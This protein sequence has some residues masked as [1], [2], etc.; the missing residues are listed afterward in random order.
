MDPRYLSVVHRSVGP[1]LV[2]SMAVAS[3]A[4]AQD[5]PGKALFEDRCGTC[6]GADGNGGEHARGMTRA[7]PDLNDSQLTTLIRE[8]LP[9][10]G[11]PAINVSDA[12]LPQVIAFVRTLKPRGGFQ[13]YRKS[14]AMI[15]GRTLDGMVLNEGSEDAQV[16]S[17]DNRIHLLRSAGSGKFREVT[18][19]INW[20]SYNG[21]VGGN[22]YTTLRQIDK[23]NVRRVVPKWIFRIAGASRLQGT[24][25]VADG[26]MYVTNANECFA[27]DAG[28]GRQ[29]WR[30]QRPRSTGLAG[31]AASGINRG[32]A[33]GGDKVFMVTD[34]AHLIALSRATGL[35]LW[36][37]EMAD[38]R[39]NHGATSAPLAVG[40]LVISGT[41][42]G[43]NGAQGFVAAF[44][45]ATGKEVWRFST[46]PKLGEPAWETWKGKH[47][48]YGGANA[49]FTGTYDPD[50]NTLF[51][52]TGNPGPDYNGDE[53]GG[54]NL[55]SNCILA[56]DPATGKLKWHYQFTPHDLWDWDATET[57]M[58]INTNW[59]GRPRKLL[60][61]ANRNGF[62]YVFDRTDGKLLLAKQFIK[63]LT[64]ASG[65][66]PDGK[67]IR[68]PNQ[69]PTA[70]GTHVCPS[71]DGATNWFSPSYNPTTGFYYVQVFEKCSIYTKRPVEWEQGKAFGGGS[72]RVDTDPKPQRLLYALDLQ[73]GTRKWELP[74][75]GTGSSWGGT[76]ATSTGL[77]FFG[78]D[79][80]TF[81]AADAVSGKTLWSFPAN[82]NWHA[83]PMAYQFDGQEYIATAAVG[84]IL[85]FG[86]V[87]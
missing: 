35:L 63:N 65:I 67:P 2:A 28:N 15:S 40:S 38:W 75:T 80:G 13:P 1:L 76:L 55:Y 66:G 20:T 53:R 46:L 21:D 74:Q 12:E 44:D 62:F 82:A 11:M 47:I 58:V 70:A 52:P 19:E 81:A 5:P 24:P 26:V 57:P 4:W 48:E 30:Y 42:G 32:V 7:A 77:V 71:Q 61:Q 3:I 18:S 68:N 78:D 73:T 72:Q 50:T 83:S 23:S 43:D 56:L 49:W 33:L 51:W 25:V 10:R 87:E 86:L 8:G 79:S 34:N 29:I 45:Q 39:R 64:W 69:E 27:I 84:E 85:V 31:D 16:R 59:E 17:D 14:F 37:V 60:V 22:R 36:D 6:H 41:G 9:A 54:D